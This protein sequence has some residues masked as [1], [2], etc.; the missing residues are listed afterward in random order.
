MKVPGISLALISVDL[1]SN[2]L[3]IVAV[4]F[5]ISIMILRMNKKI[6]L[7]L[8]LG[9]YTVEELFTLVRFNYHKYLWKKISTEKRAPSLS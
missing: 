1:G 9:L 2:F 3:I 7:Q 6:L 8:F 4:M 5:Q